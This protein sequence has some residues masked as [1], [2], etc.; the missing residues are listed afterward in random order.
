MVEFRSIF[1]FFPF[2]S[3][4]Q[5]RMGASENT[6]PPFVVVD[7]KVQESEFC[8]VT[9]KRPLRVTCYGS[10]SAKTPDKYLRSAKSLGYTL[11]KRGHIC[12]NGA[13]NFGCMAA[14]NDGAVF[15]N[16][17]IIGVI[18]EMF[19]VDGG[20]FAGKPVNFDDIGTHKA[21]QN[22]KKDAEGRIREICV[23][24][25]DDLQERK[26]LLVQNA[27][28]LIVL[29]GGPGTWDEFWEM[30]CARHLG[31]S[32]LPIVCVNVDSYYEPFRKMLYRAY[33]DELI[34]LKPEDIVHFAP[35]VEEAVRWIEIEVEKNSAEANPKKFDRRSSTLKRSSFFSPSPLDKGPTHKSGWQIHKYN[36]LS[37]MGL[38]FVGGVAFG[39]GISLASMRR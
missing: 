20:Y 33:E 30:A 36:L 6:T 8:S 31:I 37:Y 17:H 27:D 12:V 14:M 3:H 16:G 21:F 26:R 4:F 22:R 29:P 35:T 11:A 19:L 32:N 25:G 7:P 24:G 13:G 1:D 18:H 9:A 15:G 39:A 5:G 10:S 34:K 28:A 38:T 2:F 23:A